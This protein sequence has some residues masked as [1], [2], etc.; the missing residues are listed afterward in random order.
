MADF[1]NLARVKQSTYTY[2][3]KSIAAECKTIAYEGKGS[4]LECANAIG[5]TEI[6]GVVPIGGAIVHHVDRDFNPQRVTV[7]RVHGGLHPQRVT[8]ARVHGGLHPRRVNEEATLS[9]PP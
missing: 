2:N 3:S 5:D 8:V 1:S 6:F 9:I 7:A 4:S